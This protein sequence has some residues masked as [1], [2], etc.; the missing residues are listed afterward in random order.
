VYDEFSHDGSDGLKVVFSLFVDKSCDI[1]FDHGIV[2]YGC[3]GRQE[4]ASPAGFLKF[5]KIIVKTYSERPEEAL[6]LIVDNYATHNTPAVRKWLLAH[7]RFILYFT[8][9]GAVRLN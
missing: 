8:P 3:P 9:T 6:H 4:Q 2:D 7:P 1:S 5:L